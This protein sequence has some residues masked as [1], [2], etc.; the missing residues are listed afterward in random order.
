MNNLKSPIH[1]IGIE[2]RTTNDNGR[3]F[4]EIPV[5]WKHF[6]KEGVSTKIPNKLNNDIYAVYTNFENE[7][8]NN[9][10]MYSLIIGSSVRPEAIPEI[11]FTKVI[12]PSGYYRVFPVE[13][14]R[15]DKVGEAWQTIWAIPESEKHQWTFKCEFECYRASNE[16]DI[17]IGVNEVF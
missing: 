6:M 12:I 13:K 14:G 15:P 5:F 4:Y 3:S 11:G 10:G 1:I 8:K 7:G 2:L 16:I 9:Q 17:F